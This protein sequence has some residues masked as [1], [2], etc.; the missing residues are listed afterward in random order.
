MKTIQIVTQMEGGGAQRVAMLLQEGL[1]QKG[2]ECEVWFLYKKRATYENHTNVLT[3]LD[4]PPEGIK[5]YFYIIKQ[6]FRLI[7][8]RKPIKIISHTHYANILTLPI[9]ALLGVKK[10]IAVQHNPV[11]TYPK[12][13]KKM[14]KLIGNLGV[15]TKNVV[16]SKSVNES[17]NSY[18]KNYKDRLVQI[19]NG[20]KVKEPTLGS[21]EIKSQLGIEKE[22]P[23][24]INVG[25]LAEQKNQ[26]Y[27]IDLIAKM[28]GV[29]L[30]IV[31]DGELKE[32]LQ[33][34]CNVLDC[35]NRVHFLGEVPPDEISNFL[36]ASNVFVF[37][38]VFEAMGLALVEAMSIGLPVIA[39]DL[40]ATREVLAVKE[41]EKAN[42][43][44]ISVAEFEKCISQIKEILEDK[45][46]AVTLG[47][48]A[49]ERA[50][51]YSVENMTDQYQKL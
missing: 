35:K 45:E 31:G 40:P 50:K 23:V 7:R 20:V 43:I 8:K 21:D 42:G 51:L 30:L 4:R 27:L 24:I 14:D 5:D 18:P 33:E 48:N 12:V 22:T 32:E 2:E 36:N 37:P 38:S 13:A 10:R 34:Y 3:I 11:E 9:A 16:V 44:I 39:N 41:G 29:H 6:L 49:K 26:K 47:N 15:Y 46:L 17:L 1:L 19:F 25:R 28:D